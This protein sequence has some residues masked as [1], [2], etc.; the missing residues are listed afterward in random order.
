MRARSVMA[1]CFMAG[2]AMQLFVP[3]RSPAAPQAATRAEEAKKWTPPN[4]S[5]IPPGPLGDS[6]R[7]GLQIFNDTPRYAEA[8]VGNKMSC[9]SCHVQGGTVSKAIP[10]VGVPGLFPM[11]R[12]REKSVVTFQQR[13]NQCFERSE[14][15]RALPSDSP[16]MIALVAYAQWLSKGQVTGR[17]F[18][19]RGLVKLPALTGDPARGAQ[20]FTKQCALCHGEDGAGKPP[21]FPALWGP[22]SYNAGAGMNRISTMAAFVQHN[23]PQTNPGSLTPQQAYDVAAYVN[24]KPHTPFKGPGH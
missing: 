20:I 4:P 13:I 8:Y 5:T 22:D 19:G 21:V 12:D 7:V 3:A 18:P 6:I 1:V 15:G 9:G 10:L 2:L 24:S 23:M 16:E 14:N 11:Y 17:P